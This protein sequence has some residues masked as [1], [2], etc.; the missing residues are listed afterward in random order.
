MNS[1][2]LLPKRSLFT[3]PVATLDDNVWHFGR[4]GDWNSR[5]I[6]VHVSLANV[7]VSLITNWIGVCDVYVD[8]S[9]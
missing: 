6:R 3:L 8:K 2:R 4:L 5:F 7:K 9:V 1:Q